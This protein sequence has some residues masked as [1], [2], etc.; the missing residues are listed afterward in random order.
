MPPDSRAWVDITLWI[1]FSLTINVPSRMA[2]D[3]RDDVRD[4]SRDHCPHDKRPGS[5]ETNLISL[6]GVMSLAAL[7][8]AALIYPVN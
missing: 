8:G 4:D 1:W 6:W 7:V 2:F 3:K 5:D